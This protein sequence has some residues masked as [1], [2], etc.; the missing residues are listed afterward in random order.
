[1]GLGNP[2]HPGRVQGVSSHLGWKEGFPKHAEMYRKHDR[3]KKAMRDYFKEE[4]KQEM[5]QML[6]EIMANPDSEIR[7]QLA[8]VMSSQ[9]VSTIQPPQMITQMP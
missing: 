6:V 5:K 3:Y 1:M 2:K 7:Q 4:A 8:S 9:Q